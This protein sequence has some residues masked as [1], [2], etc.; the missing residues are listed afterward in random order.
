MIVIVVVA[1]LLALPSVW[2]VFVILVS[3]PCFLLIGARWV[4]LGSEQGPVALGFAIVTIAINA[5]YTGCCL[6]PDMYVLLPLCLG[7]AVIALPLIVG[8]GTAWITLASRADVLPRRFRRPA[9]FSVFVLA[10]LPFLTILTMWPLRVAFLAARPGL[11]SLA[12]QVAAGKAVNF[13]QQVGLFR[14]EGS[15]FKPPSGNIGLMI[16]P[17]PAGSTGFVRTRPVPR[18]VGR[19]PIIGSNLYVELGWGWSYRE[20]D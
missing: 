16:D 4:A 7:W 12:D 2:A 10:M 9:G 13:P 1:G 3:I 8:L 19:D 18:P 5:L 20:E 17:N 14:I 11:E 15:A 6:E